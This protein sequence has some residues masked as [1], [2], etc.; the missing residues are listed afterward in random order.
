MAVNYNYNSDQWLPYITFISWFTSYFNHK[1]DHVKEISLKTYYNT[2][3][4]ESNVTDNS[5]W[6]FVVETF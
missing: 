2:N 5:A 6:E 4:L 1:N 3:I